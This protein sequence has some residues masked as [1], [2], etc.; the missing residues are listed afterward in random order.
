[1]DETFATLH[2]GL[3]G[4]R[5]GNIGPPINPAVTTRV[6][7]F[8]DVEALEREL[9]FGDVACVLAEPAMTNVGIVPPAPGFHAVLRDLTRKHGTLLI[10][11]ETHTICAGPG[12]STKADA[13]EP[14]VLV[15]G[16]AIGG[17][18]PGAAY[19]VTQ[20]VADRIQAKHS[21]E[22]CDTGGIGGTLA[23]N[24]LSLAAMRAT[25]EKVLT[26][27]AFQCMIPLAERWAVGVRSG[28][29]EFGVPWHVTRLGC[30]A[31]YLFASEAPSNGSE[32]HDAMDFDLERFLHL[33]AMNRGILLTPFH[34]M[35]L[36]SPQTEA[37]DIDRHTHVFRGAL[38]ELVA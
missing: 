6:V 7:E 31:E 11:D 12:G 37:E 13:L 1:M 9:A 3:T 20:E 24:A 22:D 4:P 23:G 17:G 26:D 38:Q 29:E 25:L 2:E 30:R 8:N 35:A 10:L 16:K 27:S 18:V 19:G 28:I 32:A 34:N 14:D 36:M 15:F 33:Y 21:L 5:R